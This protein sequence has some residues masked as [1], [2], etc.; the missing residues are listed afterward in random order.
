VPFQLHEVTDV[1]VMVGSQNVGLALP[2]ILQPSN[3]QIDIHAEKCQ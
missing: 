1:R 3:A 2:H